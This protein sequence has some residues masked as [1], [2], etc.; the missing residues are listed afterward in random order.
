MWV[1]QIAKYY[2]TPPICYCITQV[3]SV[4]LQD[5]IDLIPWVQYDINTTQ[6]LCSSVEQLAEEIQSPIEHDCSATPTCDGV[7][8]RLEVF[9]NMFIVETDILSCTTPPAIDVIVKD[10]SEDVVYSGVFDDNTTGIIL[11]FRLK[12]C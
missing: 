9:G 12:C 6:C 3:T 10:S 1:H 2:I 8:C 5:D 7:T 4:G 11:P